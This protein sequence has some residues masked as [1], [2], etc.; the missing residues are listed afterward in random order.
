[1]AILGITNR[2]ENWQTAKYFSPLVG[3]ASVRL[4]RRLA[5]GE[6]DV[7]EGDVRVEL[8]WHPIRD[9]RHQEK[10][11]S[12]VAQSRVVAAYEGLFS[13]L[14]AKVKAFPG[15]QTPDGSYTTSDTGKLA[16][17]IAN[18][19]VDIVLESPGHLFIGEAKHEMRFH[20]SGS[21][22]L[23][24][25]LI[26]EYVT[27]RVLLDLLGSEKTV[28]PFVVGSTTAELKRQ[29]QVQFMLDQ[30]WMDPKNVLEWSDIEALR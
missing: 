18:T 27:A 6:R 30:G 5:S 4:V 1:M 10:L 14:G 16:S 7:H 15:L 26:R 17:N 25:Q 22:V 8:F 3:S 21:L 24:H 11:T 9:W 29:K 19:E 2:T 23:T 20:A 12:K 28:V 13:D